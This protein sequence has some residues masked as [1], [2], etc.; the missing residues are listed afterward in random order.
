LLK[1]LALIPCTSQK[2]DEPGP[3]RE[4]WIGA[5]FQLTLMH[6]EEFYDEIR[7]M[8]FK[9]G[10]I[11]P[12]FVIEPYD[13]NIHMEPLAERVRWKRMVM[14]QIIETVNEIKPGIVGL[15]VGKADQDWLMKAFGGRGVQHVLLPWAGLGT[16]RR[17]E[18]AYGGANP[19]EVNGI[20]L[21]KEIDA[22]DQS[23]ARDPDGAQVAEPTWKMPEH[24]R[25]HVDRDLDHLGEG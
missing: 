1:T 3:A 23:E 7:I 24:P 21:R 22:D 15:Y 16:G 18:A 11:T 9:Y 12:D 5:H 6:A 4:V 17:Q 8:S 2:A 19:F 20:D 14:R 13:T 25:P 10:L